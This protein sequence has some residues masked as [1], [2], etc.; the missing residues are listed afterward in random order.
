[1]LAEKFVKAGK[2]FAESRTLSEDTIKILEMP[3]IPKEA[4]LAAING[5]V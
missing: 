3:M 4:Y 5:T 2:E 1:P